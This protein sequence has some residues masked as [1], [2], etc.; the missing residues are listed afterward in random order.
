MKITA[1]NSIKYTN[2]YGI[3]NNSRPNTQTTQNGV[4]NPVYY[5]DYNVNINFGKRSA[6]GLLRTGFQQEQ[7]AGNYGK[8]SLC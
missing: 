8:I 5:S 7:H 4:Y 3:K 1:I 2:Q 6:G